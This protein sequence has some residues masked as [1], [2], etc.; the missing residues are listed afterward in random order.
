M[1]KPQGEYYVFPANMDIATLVL[2]IQ[3]EINFGKVF[4]AI[5]GNI[6]SS[7]T[8]RTKFP[9]KNNITVFFFPCL[10]KKKKSP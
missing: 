4:V 8:P 9:L 1:A 3:T 2:I 7:K 10:K 5:S 6:F